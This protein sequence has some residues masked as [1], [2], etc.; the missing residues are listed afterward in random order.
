MVG[1]FYSIS[2]VVEH[3]FLD[4]IPWLVEGVPADD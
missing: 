4:N 3:V 1:I 2:E